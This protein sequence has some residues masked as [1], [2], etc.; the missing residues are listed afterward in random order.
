V[1]TV[2]TGV[3][4]GRRE[5]LS[6]VILRE[7]LAALGFS[8]APPIVVPDDEEQIATLLRRLC[9]EERVDVI[10]TTGGTGLTPD[11]VTPEATRRLLERELAGIAEAIRR[12]G[13]E[14][15]PTAVLSRGLAGT[16]GRS[17]IVNVAGSTGAARDALAVLGPVLAHAVELM[18]GGHEHPTTGGETF[19]ATAGAPDGEGHRGTG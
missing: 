7:G 3:F 16:R 13:A 17:L 18:A 4:H 11:D 1:V 8:V 2:S 10:L 6:G 5:D 12:K 15:T 19:G 9:D 14:K